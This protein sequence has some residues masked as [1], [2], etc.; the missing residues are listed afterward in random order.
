M[1]SD[2]LIRKLTIAYIAIVLV[3]SFV[4]YELVAPGAV[5]KFTPVKVTDP[6]EKALD[7]ANDLAK[8]LITLSTALI[9]GC[10]WLM[11]RP[12]TNGRELAERLVWSL[13]SLV[14]LSASMYFGFAAI[15]STLTSLAF[16]GFSPLADVV[17]WP[18]TLQYY[19]FA[20]GAIVLGLAC[21][22]SIN[23]IV[24]KKGP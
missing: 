9:G 12:L 13:L 7:L 24:E 2:G 10:I 14:L 1:I 16:G 21:L 5:L 18:Q 3:G 19:F 23:A 22:R 20:A 17:W 15:N 11:T 6:A 8:Q 4:A